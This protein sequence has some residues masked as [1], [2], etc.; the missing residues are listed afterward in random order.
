MLSFW[1]LNFIIFPASYECLFLLSTV[2]HQSTLPSP[3]MISTRFWMP[4]SSG[5]VRVQLI[6]LIHKHICHI[7]VHVSQKQITHNA[8]QPLFLFIIIIH[9]PMTR[10]AHDVC[11]ILFYMYSCTFVCTIHIPMVFLLT[12]KITMLPYFLQIFVSPMFPPPYFSQWFWW[13]LGIGGEIIWI[14]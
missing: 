8:M 11:M 6:E 13:R 9:F 14:D 3:T 4:P 1:R 5:R 7:R 2:T 12:D 10:F